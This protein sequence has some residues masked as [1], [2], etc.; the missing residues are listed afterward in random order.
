MNNIYYT[1]ISIGELLDKISILQIKSNKILDENKKKN[2]D[3][4]LNL[5]LKLI[6]D[7]IIKNNYNYSELYQVNE[8]LW[9]KEDKIRELEKKKQFDNL[10]IDTARS[11]YQ[12]ND[13]RSEIK[14]NINLLYKS[15]LIEEKF[16]KSIL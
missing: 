12:L 2:I 8:S 5:L 13:K 6:D 14:K 15:I 4:E 16:Y 1:P 10:F 11:I 3:K 9:N 7:N